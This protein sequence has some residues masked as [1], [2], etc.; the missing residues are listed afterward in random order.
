MA[1]R[2]R[3][4]GFSPTCLQV[5]NAGS[6]VPCSLPPPPPPSLSLHFFF[7]GVSCFLSLHP[8]SISRLYLLF[9]AS[10]TVTVKEPQTF[11]MCW[12]DGDR[13]QAA[14]GRLDLGW[15]ELGPLILGVTLGGSLGLSGPQF[16][17]LEGGRGHRHTSSPLV[18][19]SHRSPRCGHFPLP[20]HSQPLLGPPAFAP[21]AFP[22]WIT[23]PLPL[24]AAPT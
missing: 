16:P 3:A 14:G 22:A 4:R 9:F 23:L 20:T 13:E 21:A 6:P 8:P 1:C 7:P 2:R 5:R 10:K 11:W 19:V 24:P 15:S 17:H 18:P 12:S